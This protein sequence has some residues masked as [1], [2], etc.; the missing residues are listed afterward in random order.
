MATTTQAP[1]NGNVAIQPTY[2]DTYNH[3][4]SAVNNTPTNFQQTQSVTPSNAPS[5]DQKNDISKDE[6]GWFFVEQYYTT[7]SRSPEKLHLFYSRRS[8]LVFGTEAETV[9]VAIGQKVS[10]YIALYFLAYAKY[11]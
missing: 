6:V 4:H 2:V 3:G 11:L 7:M 1:L 9:P 10:E 5:N 8:Q